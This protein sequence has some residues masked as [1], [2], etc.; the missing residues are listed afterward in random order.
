MGG[1]MKTSFI[2]LN[3]IA[4]I[5]WQRYLGDDLAFG[6]IDSYKE[7]ADILVECA[8]PDLLVFPIMFCYRQYLELLLKN[9][10]YKSCSEE[11]YKKFICQVGHNI[12]KIWIKVRPLLK[13][14]LKE[15]EFEIIDTVIKSFNKLDPT[16]FTFRYEYDKQMNRNLDEDIHL[17]VKRIKDTI[18][19]VEEIL[20]FTYDD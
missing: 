1:D 10:Y 15:K 9:I 16:S 12:S 14:D 8:C 18:G 4:K 19:K 20:L 2:D 13:D 6:Y 3:Y 5:G 7:A 17:D 11:Q